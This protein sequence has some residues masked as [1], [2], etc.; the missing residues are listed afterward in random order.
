MKQGSSNWCSLGQPNR[1][2][3][4]EVQEGGDIYLCLTHVER[5]EKP[6]HYKAIILQVKINK[7]NKNK[8]D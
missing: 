3:R 4:L 5:K 1:G 7:S 6:T 8:G 2:D